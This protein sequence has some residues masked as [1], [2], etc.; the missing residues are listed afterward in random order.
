MWDK[1]GS[2]VKISKK[3]TKKYKTNMG[4]ASFELNVSAPSQYYSAGAPGTERKKYKT[5]SFYKWDAR[6][7]FFETKKIVL[8]MGYTMECSLLMPTPANFG[9]I[10]INKPNMTWWLTVKIGPIVGSWTKYQ[11]LGIFQP[12]KKKLSLR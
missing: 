9:D 6:K 4:E 5:D 2:P 1:E 8:P 3:F 11:H 12:D 7:I 10:N